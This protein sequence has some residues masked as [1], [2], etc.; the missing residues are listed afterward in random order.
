MMI[1]ITRGSKKKKRG[2]WSA[3]GWQG[4]GKVQLWPST[5]HISSGRTVKNNLTSC[6]VFIFNHVFNA[7]IFVIHFHILAACDQFLNLIPPFLVIPLFCPL[8]LQ[9][10]N[11]HTLVITEIYN[12]SC[13]HNRV[14]PA[15]LCQRGTTLFLEQWSPRSGKSKTKFSCF[16]FPR[17]INPQCRL[18]RQ[19]FGLLGYASV[20]VMGNGKTKRKRGPRL[21][22]GFG[23]GPCPIYINKLIDMFSNFIWMSVK[24][25]YGE[26]EKCWWGRG[27]TIWNVEFFMGSG[28]CCTLQSEKFH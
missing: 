8:K 11:S 16:P 19:M 15:A 2:W 14:A 20:C 27:E 7:N 5:C 25:H 1:S 13:S 24:C 10:L 9:D 6:I 3:E 4:R 21:G 22:F 26:M 12:R 28:S 18:F 23:F 17:A